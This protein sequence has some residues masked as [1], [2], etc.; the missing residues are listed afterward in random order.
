MKSIISLLL[1]SIILLAG[2]AQVEAIYKTY[3]EIPECAARF[4]QFPEV[5]QRQLEYILD[6]LNVL[7]PSS[8]E[9]IHDIQD[10]QSMGITYPD[11]SKV[12]Y[13]NVLI[14]PAGTPPGTTT[15]VPPANVTVPNNLQ[16]G[17]YTLALIDPD[18]ADRA[19]FQRRGVLH[20]LVANI[21]F[22]SKGDKSKCVLLPYELGLN[23]EPYNGPATAPNSGLHRYSYLLFQQSAPID[24]S[25]AFPTDPTQNSRRYIYLDSMFS[26]YF[27][28]EMELVAINF[29]AT[30]NLNPAA[31][32]FNLGGA[33]ATI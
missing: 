1:L 30:D 28:V 19:T 29:F 10:L 27:R 25:F 16:S 3:N 12:K 5:L 9:D 6:D 7:N 21:P 33:P 17:L 4:N 32:G 14:Y 15:T 31:P 8:I 22:D 20:W 26:A 11:G 2:N 24:P 18:A 13:G 23:V